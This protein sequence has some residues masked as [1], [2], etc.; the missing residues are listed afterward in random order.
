MGD[1]GK[2]WLGSRV[3]EE[4]RF[5]AFVAWFY[6]HLVVILGADA[7]LNHFRSNQTS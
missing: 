2:P 1:V 5:N 7:F 4:K 3:V 6:C